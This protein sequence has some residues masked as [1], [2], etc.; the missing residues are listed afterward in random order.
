MKRL[1]NLIQFMY[2]Q[3]VIVRFKSRPPEFHSPFDYDVVDF[4][5]SKCTV[6]K[7]F[8]ECVKNLLYQKRSYTMEDL[9]TFQRHELLGFT[10][11]QRDIKEGGRKIG[12]FRG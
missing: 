1:G 9:L 8:N 5:H 4:A 11:W 7:L 12:C 2:R 6:N 3:V 10:T